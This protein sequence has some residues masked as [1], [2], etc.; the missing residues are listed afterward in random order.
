MGKSS[1]Y[2]TAKANKLLGL[3]RR[4]CP[5]LTDIKVKRPLYLA[6][7]EVWSPSHFNLK[8]QKAERFQTRDTR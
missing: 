5:M 2:V 3:V 4:T 8:Q 6:L 7:T 1:S